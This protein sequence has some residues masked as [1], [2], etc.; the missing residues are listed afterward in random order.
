M[1]NK[2]FLRTIKDGVLLWAEVTEESFN[3]QKAMFHIQLVATND[4]IAGFV[5][6]GNYNGQ[7][8]SA[9]GMIRRNG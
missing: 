5:G 9:A 3:Q 4:K 8:Y 2:F 7:M 1:K 6:H